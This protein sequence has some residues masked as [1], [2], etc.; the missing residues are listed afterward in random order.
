MVMDTRHVILNMFQ[1]LSA[2][3]GRIRRAVRN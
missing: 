1:N 2:E 3:N